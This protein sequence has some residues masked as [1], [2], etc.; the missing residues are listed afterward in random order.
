MVDI[1]LLSTNT[2]KPCARERKNA[3]E[4]GHGT[5][6]GTLYKIFRPQGPSQPSHTSL[7]Y[8]SV[9]EGSG[10]RNH[11]TVPF[12]QFIIQDKG[13]SKTTCEEND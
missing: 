10:E 12:P 6:K 5:P 9:T 13:K 4:H 7:L 11:C 3:E 1:V 2:A 8:L